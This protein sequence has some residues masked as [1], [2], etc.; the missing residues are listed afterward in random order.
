[1]EFEEVYKFHFF[2]FEILNIHYIG[3]NK[4]I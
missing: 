4:E 2:K 3:V 1:M